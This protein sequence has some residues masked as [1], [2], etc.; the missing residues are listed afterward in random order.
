MN[1]IC[2]FIG[3]VLSGLLVVLLAVVQQYIRFWF[4]SLKLWWLK[5]ELKRR[6]DKV[7]KKHERLDDLMKKKLRELAGGTK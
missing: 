7:K 4:L 2:A 1:L 6:L 3:F 5:R